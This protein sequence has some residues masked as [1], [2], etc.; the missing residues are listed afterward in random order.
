MAVLDWFNNNEPKVFKSPTEGNYIIKLMSVTLT[1]K[2]EIGR[3]LSEVSA[4]AVEVM[5]YTH[6]NLIKYDLVLL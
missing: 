4:N 2:K 1:P 6:D 5:Q 3:L